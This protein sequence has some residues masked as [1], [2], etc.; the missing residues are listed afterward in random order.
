MHRGGVTKIPVKGGELRVELE[1][2][3]DEAPLV[4]VVPPTA[5]ALDT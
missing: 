3:G 2:F 1:A 5:D 4:N